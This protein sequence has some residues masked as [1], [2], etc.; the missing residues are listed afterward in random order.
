MNNVD[1]KT[2]K[3]NKKTSFRRQH[4][5]GVCTVGITVLLA[6]NIN[7][8]IFD[9]LMREYRAVRE[10]KMKEYEQRIDGQD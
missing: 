6:L 4:T 7:D 1:H 5:G 10:R 3:E 9:D 2:Q 8:E